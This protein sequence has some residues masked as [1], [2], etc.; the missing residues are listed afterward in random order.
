[1]P[2][3]KL[4]DDGVGVPEKCRVVFFSNIRKIS[5]KNFFW[6]CCEYIKDFLSKSKSKRLFIRN[7]MNIYT[8]DLVS[9]DSSR[10][11]KNC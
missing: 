8:K 4:I 7:D 5:E 10:H 9:I 1:M 2:T 3:N 6:C 11:E